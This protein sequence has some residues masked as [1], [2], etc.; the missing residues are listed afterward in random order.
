[1]V[2]TK[3]TNRHGHSLWLIQRF[4][5]LVMAIYSIIAIIIY[6]TTPIHSF[7]EWKALFN[8]TLFS[9]TW[10]K[11]FTLLFLLSLIVH[12]W[13]GVSDV[14]SDY[15]SNLK[16]RFTLQKMMELALCGYTFWSIWVLWNA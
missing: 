6:L 10:L 5:A 7:T 16:L 9:I 11:I 12:A 15:I 8:S 2:N 14:I 1:M 4:S 3:T 13:I